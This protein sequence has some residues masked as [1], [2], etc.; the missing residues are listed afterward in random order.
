MT[1][2]G[3]Y[4][5]ICLLV[6]LLAGVVGASNAH[7]AHAIVPEKGMLLV[8]NEQLTDPRFHNRVILVIQHDTQ[9]TAGLVINRPSR[10]LLD[11]V[12]PKGSKLAGQGRTLSYGGPVE[13]Q[14]LLAL[15]KVRN[16]PPEPAE[17]IIDN[18]YVTAVGVLDEWPDFAD[19]VVDYRVFVGYTGWVSGQLDAELLRGDW[20]L[21]PTDD[22]GVFAGDGAQ[23][24]ERLR[25]RVLKK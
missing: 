15:V 24:W 14:T 25:Q 18:L 8:A 13:P 6:L 4:L 5:R 20:H 11:A 1:A 21:L 12:L 16:H 9:G 23:L 22:Q 2:A 10:L 19:E 17:E 7:I 3:R